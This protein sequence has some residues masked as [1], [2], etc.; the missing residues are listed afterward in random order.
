SMKVMR[1]SSCRREDLSG[2]EDVLRIERA[3]QRPH[4]C[5]L[6]FVSGP[7]KIVALLEANAVFGRYRAATLSQGAVDHVFDRVPSLAAAI[8]DTGDEM[9]I[10]IAQ[11]AKD[12]QG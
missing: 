2:I 8:A 4:Q 3:L 1:L 10:S 7:G 6:R 11:V 12:H 5:D 9:E